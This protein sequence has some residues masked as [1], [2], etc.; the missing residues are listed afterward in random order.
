MSG[1]SGRYTPILQK[2]E[3]Q[4]FLY[5][6]DMFVER[7]VFYNR[8]TVKNHLLTD[9]IYKTSCVKAY[10]CLGIGTLKITYRIGTTVEL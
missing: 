8:H 5:V 10:F 6:M 2:N 9:E 7:F 3:S 4:N 1:S